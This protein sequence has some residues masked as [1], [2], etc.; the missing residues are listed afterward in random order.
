LDSSFE[1]RLKL[2][3][4]IVLISLSQV[5][6]F[7]KRYSRLLQRLRAEVRLMVVASVDCLDAVIR[8]HED[9]IRGLVVTDAS[10]MQ[11]RHELL[12]H[13][14]GAILHLPFNTWSVLFA[15]DFPIQAALAPA[16]F[17]AYMLRVIHVD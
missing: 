6:G 14:L 4:I 17:S 8:R 11:P 9:D 3:P 7:H 10:I 12:T 13:R 15:F 2:K 5:T 16:A 1:E